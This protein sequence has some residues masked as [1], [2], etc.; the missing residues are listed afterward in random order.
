MKALALAAAATALACTLF[1][2]HDSAASFY[3]P[4]YP[5]CSAR[6]TLTSGPFE[7]IKDTK[8]PYSHNAQLTVT[9]RGYLRGSYPDSEINFYIRLNGSDVFL[10]ASAGANNDAYVY[11]NA[12]PRACLVCPSYYGPSTICDDYLA[13]G[14]SPGNWACAGPSADEQ[15]IFYWAF[16]QAGQQNAW[17]LEVAAESHGHW[18][19]NWG[20]NYH[21]RFEPRT[22]CY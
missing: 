15:E 22:S 7:L 18:D 1:A 6:D 16:S 21:G 10:P 8:S 13:N 5:I 11:L 4:D 14:G 20:W 17:D 2:A 3:P 19:S 12:G 9:Y